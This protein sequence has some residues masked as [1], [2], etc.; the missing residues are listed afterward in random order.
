[1]IIELEI[2]L[3]GFKV[4]SVVSKENK[5]ACKANLRFWLLFLIIR[6][7]YTNIK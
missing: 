2:R 3:K 7:I 4:K 5:F 1:M 6:L